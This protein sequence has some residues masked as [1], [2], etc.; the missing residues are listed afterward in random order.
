MYEGHLE[1]LQHGIITPQLVDK[2]LSCI[3]FWKLE[4]SRFMMV[5]SLSKKSFAFSFNACSK[6]V[7]VYTK[8]EI[9][10]N[11]LG[12]VIRKLVTLFMIMTKVLQIKRFD[13]NLS[14]G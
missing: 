8:A 12:K 5:F 14:C 2:M 1:S 6:R 10:R 7:V 9:L 13:A 4:F 3:H 11:L